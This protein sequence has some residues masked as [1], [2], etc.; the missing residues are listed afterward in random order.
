MYES[1]YKLKKLP[2]DLLSDPDFHFMSDSHSQAYSNLQH[3]ISETKEFVAITGENGF[4]KTILHNHF[5]RNIKEK[6]KVAHIGNSDEPNDN[7][8]ELN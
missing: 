6:V 4:G 3:A 5:L 7:F 1:F 8:T 2:F